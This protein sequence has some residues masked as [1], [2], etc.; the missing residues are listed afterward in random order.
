MKRSL[1]KKQHYLHSVRHLFFK[2]VALGRPKVWYCRQT[3]FFKNV[4][5]FFIFLSIRFSGRSIC[6]KWCSRLCVVLLLEAWC[7]FW[8]PSGRGVR[9]RFY[10][11]SLCFTKGNWCFFLKTSIS[12][13]VFHLFRTW[14]AS[15]APPGLGPP[16]GD[17]FWIS[18]VASLVLEALWGPFWVHLCPFW[19][20]FT[21]FRH[22]MG[23][24]FLNFKHN[25]DLT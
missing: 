13:N 19:S 7:R 25:S 2:E 11:Q 15:G 9:E 22:P 8:A 23:S 16:P 1:V 4:F 3:D 10:E 6:R 14:L 5:S 18:L 24:Y 20:A 21:A 12:L 17:L